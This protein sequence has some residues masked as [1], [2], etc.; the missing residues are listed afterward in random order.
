MRRLRRAAFVR[1]LVAAIVPSLITS[2]L[3][4]RGRRWSGCRTAFF[5]R[6]RLWRGRRGL[7][8]RLRS[9][10]LRLRG[11]WLRPCLRRRR[12]LCGWRRWRTALRLRGRLF[13]FVLLGGRRRGRLWRSL[14]DH[15]RTIFRR[16]LSR[17]WKRGDRHQSGACEQKRRNIQAVARTHDVLV[18]VVGPASIGCVSDR[19]GAY[20]GRH[21]R[22]QPALRSGHRQT[23]S[24]EIGSVK[25]TR[26][27]SGKS[28]AG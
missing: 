15:N 20:R 12:R 14:R 21:M 13:V 3:L 11:R 23:R 10:R 5:R 24:L 18:S 25:R 2:L 6:A 19:G 7:C 8:V 22:A 27:V 4:R 1:A 26:M 17:K 16:C 28:A 9:R